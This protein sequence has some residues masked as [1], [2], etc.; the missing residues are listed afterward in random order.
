MAKTVW[1]AKL[2]L[3][4]RQATVGTGSKRVD[5]TRAKIVP[6]RTTR[7]KRVPQ[8]EAIHQRGKAKEKARAKEIEVDHLHLRK[9][10]AVLKDAIP[11][12]SRLPVADPPL[13]RIMSH[14]AT[15]TEGATV[16]RVINVTI[17]MRQYVASSKVGSAMLVKSVLLFT[18]VR[19]HLQR[20]LRA[21]A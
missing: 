17:G 16:K 19:G 10:E 14:L 3:A 9:K 20:S 7:P 15:G 5:A 12:L 21:K 8:T 1:T 18:Q 11:L 4:A 2:F 13:G 6:G